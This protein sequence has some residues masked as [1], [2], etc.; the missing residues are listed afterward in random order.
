MGR[1]HTRKAKQQKKRNRA[2]WHQL[3]GPKNRGVKRR[4]RDQGQGGGSPT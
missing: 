4:E 3:G 2:R 1:S